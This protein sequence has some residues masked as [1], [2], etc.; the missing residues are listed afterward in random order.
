MLFLTRADEPKP[1]LA[2][3]LVLEQFQLMTIDD[4]RLRLFAIEKLNVGKLFVGDSKYANLAVF[5]HQGLDAAN[6]YGC[7][8][9]TGTMAHIDGKLEHR[10]AVAHDVLAE[11]RSILA[12]FARRGGEIE[13]Y[14]YPHDAILTKTFHESGHFG[15]DYLS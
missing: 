14:K 10:E 12:L 3:L 2:R 7:V 11:T 15:I 8:L 4:G 6:V 5:R 9:A 13:E 1:V